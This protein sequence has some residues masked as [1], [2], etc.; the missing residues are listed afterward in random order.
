VIFPPGRA[1]LAMRPLCTGSPAL[2]MTIGI[3]RVLCLAAI[4]FCVADATMTSTLRPTSSV[5]KAGSRS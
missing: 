4:T 5:A 2:V 1:R 3:V